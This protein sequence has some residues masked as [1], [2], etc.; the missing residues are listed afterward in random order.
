MND[1]R[2]ISIPKITDGEKF[3]YLCRDIYR[4]NATYELVELNGRRGQTQQGVDVFA[5][6]KESGNWVGIQCKCRATGKKLTEDDIQTEVNKAK[7]FNPTITKLSIYTTSDRDVKVQEIIRNINDSDNINFIVQVKFW[8][9]IE[10]ELKELHN[11]SVYYQYYNKFFA[12]NI[13]LGHAVSK[14]FNLDLCMNGKVDSHYELMLGKIPDY[15]DKSHSNANYY[16]GT[17]FIVN[18]HENRVKLFPLRCHYS[19]LEDVFYNKIDR[20]RICKW[21]QTI[22]DLDEFI[23]LEEDKFSYSLSDKEY[24]EYT[25]SFER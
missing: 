3:E 5:R 9:D 14:L 13:T 6:E 24:S 2:T 25:E 8:S 10:E 15:K 18:L 1:L 23:A 17:Y 21:L 4:N 20:Y 22:R 7:G 11:Y 19:D 12:D 16:R